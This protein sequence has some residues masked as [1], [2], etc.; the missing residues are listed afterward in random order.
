MNP[1]DPEKDTIKM[2][3]VKKRILKAAKIKN[4]NLSYTRESPQDKQE[5]FSAE[6]LQGGRE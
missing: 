5:I 4:K 3:K 1:K 2:S 6:T